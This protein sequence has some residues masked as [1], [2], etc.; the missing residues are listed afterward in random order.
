MANRRD[1]ART[2]ATRDAPAVDPEAETFWRN[3]RMRDRVSSEGPSDERRRADSEAMDEQGR[4]D[5]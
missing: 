4:G 5:G 3:A 2:M 1:G